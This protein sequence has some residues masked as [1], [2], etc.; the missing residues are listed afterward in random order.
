MELETI[1]QNEIFQ[2]WKA[3][4]KKK[5]KYCVFSYMSML[6]FKLCICV[7]QFKLPNKGPRWNR[8][9]SKEGETEYS[10]KEEARIWWINREER[11]DYGEQN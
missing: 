3:K 8:E 10:V 2:T 9:P 7:F 6:T 1:N 5:T 4:M 11:R